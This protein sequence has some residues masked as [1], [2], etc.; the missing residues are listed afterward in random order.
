MAILGSIFMALSII[1]AY[2]MLAPESMI[3]PGLGL[4]S[5]GLA[6]KMV[7]MAL[8]Q[9]NVLAWFIAKIFVWKFEWVYQVVSLSLAVAAGWVAKLF[10]ESIITAHVIVLMATSAAIYLILMSLVVYILPWLLGI[11][12]ETIQQ[13]F[14]NMLG[15][16]S[17]L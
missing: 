17:I 11:E 16:K 6:L 8:I 9:V 12:R 4:A 14:T 1:A 7:I 15:K 13:Y 10:V 3:V 5:Q 2:F